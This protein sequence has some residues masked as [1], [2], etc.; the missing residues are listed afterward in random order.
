V[1]RR[2]VGTLLELA[3]GETG[4]ICHP[5]QA[6]LSQ[7]VRAW[8]SAGGLYPIETYLAVLA[9]GDLNRGI[10][11]YQVQS[12]A[13]AELAPLPPETRLQELVY[14]EGFWDNAALMVILTGV[15]ARTQAKY[16]ERGYRF[17]HLD[18]G[19]LAQNLLL[20]SEDL[21]MAVIPIGG[22]CE[23]GLAG[24]MGLDSREECP[25]YVFLLGYR[26]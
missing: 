24:A 7:R 16:G 9:P 15:F 13:L 14:A 17:I 8:P 3:C 4:T 18:A 1:A 12:H 20:V 2:D 22:F 11:H 10:Y 5:Q 25:L 6:G 19:H 26:E 21:G 23:D